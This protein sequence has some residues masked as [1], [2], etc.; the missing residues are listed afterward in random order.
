MKKEN[1]TKN[2]CK[3]RDILSLTGQA[4]RNSVEKY[5]FGFRAGS[6]FQAAVDKENDTTLGEA[7]VSTIKDTAKST[8]SIYVSRTLFASAKLWFMNSAFGSALMSSALLMPLRTCFTFLMT[9]FHQT[10]LG[11]LFASFSATVTLSFTSI[12]TMLL[13]GIAGSQLGKLLSNTFLGR[14]FFDM[15]RFLVSV[16]ASVLPLVMVSMVIGFGMRAYQRRK[17]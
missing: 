12:A 16:T 3:K 8:G 13:T 7:T 11:A 10:V 9:T 5:A 14:I 17:K 1:N 4:M 15:C 6:Q 2:S